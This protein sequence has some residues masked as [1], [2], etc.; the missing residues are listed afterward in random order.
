M[1]VL[2]DR[3][4]HLLLAV[5]VVPRASQNGIAGIQGEVLKVRL[6][7]PPLDGKANAALIAYLADLLLI[8]PYQVNLVSGAAGRQKVIQLSGINLAEARARLGII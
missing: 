8:R 2:E 4:D 7:A 6:T 3:G 1:A 5:R